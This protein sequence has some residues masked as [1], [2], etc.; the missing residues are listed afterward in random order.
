MENETRPLWR[1][2]NTLPLFTPLAVTTFG[3]MSRDYHVYVV[4]IVTRTLRRQ[5]FEEILPHYEVK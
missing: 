1:L 5:L 4:S 2:Q 3:A